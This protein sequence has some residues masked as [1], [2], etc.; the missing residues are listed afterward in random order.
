MPRLSRIAATLA[1]GL[2]L[3]ACSRNA[4]IGSTAAGGATPA[5]TIV[6]QAEN[7]NPAQMDLFVVYAG[8]SI[9]LGQ[10]R[11]LDRSIFKLD[12]TQYPSG[13]IAIIADPIGQTGQ[14]STGRLIVRGGQTIVFRIASNLNQSTASV[15]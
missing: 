3:A 5:S 8:Q 2:S 9:R 1:A 6:V 13:E 14:A 7:G 11:G 4:P 12:A 15:Q 10:V